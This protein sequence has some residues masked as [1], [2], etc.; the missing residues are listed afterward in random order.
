M[1]VL[2]IGIALFLTACSATFAQNGD[3]AKV[4]AY[5]KSLPQVTPPVFDEARVTALAALPL[6]CIDHPQES[7]EQPHDYLW[8]HDSK[9]RPVD[10]YDKNRGFYGCSDWHSAVNSTWTMIALMKQDPKLALAPV[11]RQRLM[12]HMGSSNIAGE[13]AF[14]S[15]AKGWEGKNFE[16][17][18]GYT[19][20]LKVYGELA[21]WNDPDAKKLAANV[22][23]LAKLLAGEYVKYLKSMPYPIRVG[24]HPNSALTMGFAL[25]YTDAV[26][27]P[28]VKAAVSETAMRFFG[29][30]KNCPTSYEPEHSDFLSPCLT[31]AMLMSRIMDQ[32]Q[33]VSWLDSFL[34]PVTSSEFQVYASDIDSS[35]ISGS[36]STADADDKDGLLGA[37]AHLIGLAFQRAA[38]LVRIASALPKDDP[39]VAV[40]QRLAA[41]NARQGFNKMGDAGYAGQHWLATYA[42]LYMQGAA[43]K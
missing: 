5:L 41:M 22:E 30:D 6:S 13:V 32:K 3:N 35:R 15:A 20:L 19:W 43:V 18:Y 29:K 10:D 12:D 14:F 36:G 24:Q 4:A 1:R 27:D 2:C 9:Q 33:Y 34:P 40:F 23:P 38:S 21:S 42:V 31:E 17:P 37:K 7:P 26:T 16:R 8:I 11:I 39:R 25:D 28:A